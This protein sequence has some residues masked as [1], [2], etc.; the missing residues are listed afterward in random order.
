[1]ISATGVNQQ[2]MRTKLA[3]EAAMQFTLLNQEL[4][5]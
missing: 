1:M 4:S 5:E 3:A 2:D